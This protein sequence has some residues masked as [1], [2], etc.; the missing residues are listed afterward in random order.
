MSE[1]LGLT[2]RQH[3]DLLAHLRGRRTELARR[4]DVRLHGHDDDRHAEAGLPKRS[5]ETDDDG[6]A[7]AARM[8]D[9]HALSRIAAELEEVEAALRRIAEGSYGECMDCGDAVGAGR[10]AAYP[11]ALRCAGCQ[12]YVETHRVR[13]RRG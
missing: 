11:T 12:D 13:V 9:V 4:L 10:L 2:E 5:E 7:E 1:A 6:A 8:A 3:A